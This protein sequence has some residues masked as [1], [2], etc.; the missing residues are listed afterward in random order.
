MNNKK[1]ATDLEN[2]SIT[3]VC[4]RLYAILRVCADA[5]RSTIP[6]SVGTKKALTEEIKSYMA[7]INAWMDSFSCES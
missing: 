1:T 5:E 3:G 6:L 4:Y 7:I 2:V